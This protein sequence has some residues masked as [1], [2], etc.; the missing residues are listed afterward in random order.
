GRAVRVGARGP[1]GAVRDAGAGLPADGVTPAGAGQAGR[2]EPPGFRSASA[3]AFRRRAGARRESRGPPAPKPAAAPAVSPAVRVRARPHRT[4]RAALH[5][6]PSPFSRMAAADRG[7]LQ[8][9]QPMDFGA[10]LTSAL[11]IADLI[12]RSVLSV[13]VIMR[14]EPPQVTLAW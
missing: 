12:I 4:I 3:P 13:R 2:G 7:S 5:P 11:L 6:A 8:H 14:G 1:R 9:P 10:N